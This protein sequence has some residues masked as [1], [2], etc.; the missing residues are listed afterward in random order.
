MLLKYYTFNFDKINCEHEHVSSLKSFLAALD[1]FEDI[2]YFEHINACIVSG[3]LSGL[4]YLHSRDVVHRDLKPDNVLV[5]NKH[6]VACDVA[7]LP[8]WW[9]VDPITAVLTDFGESRATLLQT[10]SLCFT[11]TTNLFR[12]SPAFIAPE[13]RE[14]SRDTRANISDLKCMDV[15]SLGM[16]VF[17]IIN[18]GINHPYYFEVQDTVNSHRDAK[19][20]LRE[21][22]S[23][24]C[25]PRH[26]EKYNDQQLGIWSCL[27][28]VYRACAR[29]D[30]KTRPDE[31]SLHKQLVVDR[32]VIKPLM[33]S[34][35]SISDA[36]SV[37]EMEGDGETIADVPLL[38]NA[39]TLLALIIA[40]RVYHSN[41]LAVDK[42]A[43]DAI[44]N[45][46][47]TAR[48]VRS[49]ARS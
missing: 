48:G 17:C 13:G 12:G 47:V 2:A 28:K 18:P 49:T 30:A 37:A 24:G 10:S 8:T 42:V 27:V 6:Y 14:G 39:C 19:I 25:L 40:D 1:E 3:V 29:F 22:H 21:L 35:A 11:F 15:W 46:P 26:E 16:L 9:A 31:D 44:L 34:Q 43:N 32:V 7:D 41:T 36:L 4:H 33:V 5:S 38:N 23:K 45:F 20:V